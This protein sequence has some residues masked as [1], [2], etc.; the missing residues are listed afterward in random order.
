[1][2]LARLRPRRSS[3]V[4]TTSR[5]RATRSASALDSAGRRSD[6]T[7]LGD[8][9]DRENDP[10]VRSHVRARGS[11]RWR[12]RPSGQVRQ[13][14]RARVRSWLAAEAREPRAAREPDQDA[15]ELV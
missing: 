9:A 10:R 14:R 5:S 2:R 15:R 12:L 13:R 4:W 1:M 7:S 6:R 8:F 3:T 11:V